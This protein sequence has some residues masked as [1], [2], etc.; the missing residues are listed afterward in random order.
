[1]NTDATLQ[2][3]ADDDI[4]GQLLRR[5]GKMAELATENGVV[6]LDWVDGVEQAL[7]HPEWLAECEREA[8]EIL[9][10]GIKHIIWAG[11]GGSVQTVY[12]LK[13]MGLL[14]TPNLHVYPC[15]STDPA[16]LNR[17]LREIAAD[18]GQPIRAATVM[19]RSPLAELL[20]RTMMIGVS[21]GMTSE[22]PITHLE[23][24]EGLLKEHDLDSSAHIQV[25]TLPGSYLDNFAR[26]RGCRMF[27]IQL[28]SENHTG[29]RFSAP[30]T[31][32]FVRPVCLRLVADE[33]MG[34]GLGIPDAP[35]KKALRAIARLVGIGSRGPKCDGSGIGAVLQMIQDGDR[36]GHSLTRFNRQLIT[37]EH[38]F[39]RLGVQIALREPA[40]NRSVAVP[41]DTDF[42]PWLEQ[43][44]EE[45]LGK[46]GKGF[47][48]FYG[49]QLWQSCPT[50][51]T[52]G[53]DDQADFSF[54]QRINTGVSIEDYAR[55]MPFALVGG[56]FASLKLTV[57]T[58]A[59]LHD[60]VFS[61]QPAVEAYKAYARKFRS[62]D[63]VPFPPADATFGSLSLHT[64][65]IVRES[66]SLSPESGERV[67]V[68]GLTRVELHAELARFGGDTQN[69]AD[70]LAAII[71]A[72]RRDGLG[73]GKQPRYLDFT[74][75]GEMPDDLR[76]VFEHAR[77]VIA[78]EALRI[79]AKIR[80]G[81]SDYHSTEQS[82]VDGPNE[83]I[84][85]R[86]VA[87]KHEQVIAGTY[88]DKFLLAQARG[89]WQA[90]EDAGRWVVMVTMPE[91]NAT[92]TRELRELFEAVRA[93]L[94]K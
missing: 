52:A 94:A 15:D 45:S 40:E 55:L 46:G 83:L 21:M 72:A 24:F 49:D 1:M 62:M 5:E 82:E 30:A 10:S 70:M 35:P 78:N 57:A 67:G 59:Y 39:I 56:L 9:Q 60:I 41:S 7:A 36:V 13:R 93:R 12:V 3:L 38:P 33:L 25:M 75:N 91:L 88:D 8:L 80:T 2:R 47:C 50:M 34:T 81:P 66:D 76:A 31:R 51:F 69:A 84:S 68:R 18:D 20:S 89:T 85:I 64:K 71:N 87:M 29:G 42:A 53:W 77:K 63:E 17:I 74:F 65:S 92:T 6:M 61:G 32:V 14:D 23:W 86:F 43:L 11:M 19:E 4:I 27:P 48:V 79:P 28:D 22:E 58:F 16:S 90:M 26:P 73:G 44:V 37:R 54:V